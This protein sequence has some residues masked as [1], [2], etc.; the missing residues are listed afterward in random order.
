MENSIRSTPAR[1]IRSSFPRSFSPGPNM[2]PLVFS[3]TRA[4]RALAYSIISTI[5][6]WSIGSPPPVQ[7][8][9]APWGP[10]SS[11]ILFQSGSG[12]RS[13]FRSR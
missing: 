6:G 11:A 9:Q 13:P 7:R 10:H 5:R 3:Q 2:L 12:S 1:M 8:I 4:P